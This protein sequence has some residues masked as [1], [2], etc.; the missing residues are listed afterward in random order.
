MRH[1]QGC[2]SNKGEQEAAST[3]CKRSERKVYTRTTLLGHLCDGDQQQRQGKNDTLSP[4]QWLFKKYN[5]EEFTD[6]NQ[7]TK[8]S[9][10]DSVRYKTYGG[11]FV[12]TETARLPIRLVEF[13]DE[14]STHKFQ[15]DAQETGGKYD[16]IIGSDIMEDM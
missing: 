4:R 10:E 11:K 1:C 14:T 16:M 6:K 2:A 15:V 3:L 8:L 12:S 5:I 13:G 7:R 9:D